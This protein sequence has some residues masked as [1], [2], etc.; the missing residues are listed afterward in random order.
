MLLTLVAVAKLQFVLQQQPMLLGNPET[1]L[2]LFVAS[3]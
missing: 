3:L 2:L 1:G